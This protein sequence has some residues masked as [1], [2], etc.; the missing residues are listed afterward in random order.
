MDVVPVIVVP[1]IEPDSSDAT[2]TSP[3]LVSVPSATSPVNE[4]VEPPTAPE[5]TSE[6]TVTVPTNVGFDCTPIVTAPLT[7]E[8]VIGAAPVT[9]VIVPLPP[10]PHATPVPMI[11]PPVLVCKH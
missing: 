7:V 4:A 6:P 11:S 8:A 9:D 5:T 1:L 10:L 3:V 2:S